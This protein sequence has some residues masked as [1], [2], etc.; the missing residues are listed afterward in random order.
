[1][2]RTLILSNTPT[3]EKDR[4]PATESP[5]LRMFKEPSAK[6]NRLILHNALNHCCLAG[7]ANESQRSIMIE[8]LE[9]CGLN[10]CVIL[11][12]DH[13]CQFRA[14]YSYCPEMEEIHKLAG[15]GPRSIQ[16]KMIE[17]LYKYN[18]DR[19]Q[20][21]PIPSK[22]MSANVDALTIQ[23]HLWQLRKKPVGTLQK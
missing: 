10:Q 3:A 4:H 9:K 8:E 1:M 19:K 14:L 13:Q 15:S 7:K 16:K 6:S 20:F 17:N 2:S 18:S 21:Q 11:F 23:G 5:G 22:T 12:R